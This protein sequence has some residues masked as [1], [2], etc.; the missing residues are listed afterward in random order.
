MRKAIFVL[1][2][3]VGTACAQRGAYLVSQKTTLT[4]AAEVVTVQLPPATSVNVAFE[5]ASVYC[6][7]ECEFTLERDG[8]AATQTAATP[9]RII[10][11]D[12]APA[13]TAYRSSNVGAGTVL[14][15]YVVP[16]GGTVVLDLRLVLIKAGQNVSVR[17]SAITGVVIIQFGWKE[18]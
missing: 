16:A 17:T 14:T 8:A 3:S 7:V 2:L 9:V 1:L 13:A 5:R 11:S 12:P 18:H 10:P 15:Q 6:S 4:G